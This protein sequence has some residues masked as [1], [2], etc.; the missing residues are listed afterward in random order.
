MRS[1]FKHVSQQVFT[2]FMVFTT[3][4]ASIRIQLERFTSLTATHDLVDA[5]SSLGNAF[6]G[7]IAQ[8]RVRASHRNVILVF[9]YL[10]GIA[11][12][13]ITS[14]A[15][16]SQKTIFWATSYPITVRGVIDYTGI[17]HSNIDSSA[18]LYGSELANNSFTTFPPGGCGID[19]TPTLFRMNPGLWDRMHSLTPGLAYDVVF[20]VVDKIGGHS[21]P[22]TNNG[23]LDN[24]ILVDGWIFDVEC[25]PK[26]NT[27][28]LSLSTRNEI[29]LNGI[30]TNISVYGTCIKFLHFLKSNSSP[31]QIFTMS[32]F[33][34]TILILRSY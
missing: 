34:R 24:V 16:L 31:G 25:Q 28:E 9:L 21:E 23:Y 32:N 4:R 33:S 8:R 2:I 17:M 1:R 3:Q 18:A 30:P 14:P 27:S 19:A 11:I 15:L 13:H 29:L 6:F 20:G 22:L 26:T 7:L 10:G 12:L 5:W